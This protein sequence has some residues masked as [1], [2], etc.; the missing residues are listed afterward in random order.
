MRQFIET[1]LGVTAILLI[2]WH[3]ATHNWLAE[4]CLGGWLVTWG[5]WAW[6]T[7]KARKV[8]PPTPMGRVVRD[9]TITLNREDY[10]ISLK[11][12]K[13]PVKVK[14]EQGV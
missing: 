1:L 9:R 14:L 12:R 4:L 11:I 10:Q 6:D 2:T 13:L 5:L 7:Y 3:S 8:A